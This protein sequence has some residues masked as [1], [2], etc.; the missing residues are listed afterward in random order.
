M[1]IVVIGGTGHIGSF[2]VPRLVRAGHEVVSVSRG[3]RAPYTEAAEWEHVERLVVDREAEDEAG[4]FPARIAALGCDVV[5]DLV[6][7]TL[8]SA[9]A[10]V[11]GLRGHVGHLLHCGS[12]WRYGPSAVVP[13][14]EGGG[15]PPF[16]EYG[17]EKDR[18]ARMLQQETANGGLVT[19]SLHPGHIVGPGWAPVNPLGNFDPDVWRILADGEPLRIPGLGAEMLHHVHADD[20]A[21]AFELAVAHRDRVAGEDLNVTS[22]SAITVRGFAEAAASWFGRS[23]DLTPVTWEE[24]RSTT[25]REHADT[26]WEHLVRSHCVS[27]EK[28]RSLLGYAPKHTSTDAVRD[29][30]RWL[31]A[32][33]ELDVPSP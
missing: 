32:N 29:A 23:A 20:V 21:Q 24:F 18:I 4:T 9:E 30:L 12:I 10:L 16:G 8:P 17:V 5:I 14:V 15:T 33:D 6:C 27:I 13:I 11:E 22:A 3:T 7:F 26:S 19:T 25:S 31:V 1:R 28:A 2:L